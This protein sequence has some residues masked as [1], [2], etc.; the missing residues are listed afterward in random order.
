MKTLRINHSL[1]VALLLSWLLCV[2][3]THAGEREAQPQ[4]ELGKRVY[5]AWCVTCHGPGPGRDGRGLTG[6][7]ALEAKYDGKL[8][9]ILDERQDLTPE[10]VAAMV[11]YGV[12]VM[13]F[14]RRTEIS[15]TELAA[16]GAYLARLNPASHPQLPR[17]P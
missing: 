7:E 9:A 16:L 15:D 5:D 4:L 6:T 10:F 11:R 12:S 3:A 17:R 2:S 13:P 8:P 14:F 1:P